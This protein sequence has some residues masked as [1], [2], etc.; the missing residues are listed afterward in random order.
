MGTGAVKDNLKLI[1]RA[2]IKP[3]GGRASAIGGSFSVLQNVACRETR[4][5]CYV[6][7]YSQQE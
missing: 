4:K 6:I 1:N 7:P 5:N 3:R 2:D